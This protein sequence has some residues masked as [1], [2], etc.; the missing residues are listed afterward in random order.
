MYKLKTS[1]IQ[2]SCS[3]IKRKLVNHDAMSIPKAQVSFN[4]CNTQK[5]SHI[6][7]ANSIKFKHFL[8]FGLSLTSM[9]A[10]VINNSSNI[11]SHNDMGTPD[12][13]GVSFI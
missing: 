7:I 2:T 4:N 13:R 5:L 9:R 12:G 8:K 10:I 1:N 6:A 3:A 11:S